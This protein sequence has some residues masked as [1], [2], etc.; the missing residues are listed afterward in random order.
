MSKKYLVNDQKGVALFTVVLIFLVLVTLLGGVMFAAV[1]NQ[2][3]SILAKDHTAVYYVAESGLNM[4][5]ANLESLFNSTTT[6][7]WSSS[8][9]FSEI[10]ATFGTNTYNLSENMGKA[11]WAVTQVSLSPATYAAYSDYVFIRLSS[12]GHIGDIS[13]DLYVDVGYKISLGPG[14]LFTF[15]GA[16]ITKEGITVDKSGATVIGPIASNMENNA[17]IDLSNTSTCHGVT[18]INIPTEDFGDV[19]G[20]NIPPSALTQDIVFSDITMPDR[21]DLLAR[22]LT[23]NVT[24]SSGV[25]D[26]RR[27]N[28][29][30]GSRIF[31]L[32]QLNSGAL[33]I[34][35]NGI[36]ERE[37]IFV[38]LDNNITSLPSSIT[39]EGQGRLIFIAQFSSTMTLN[40]VIRYR[41]TEGNL[42]IDPSKVNFVLFAQSGTTPGIRMQPSDVYAGSVLSNSTGTV[43][44]K[45]KF[46]G[47]FVTMSSDV[48]VQTPNS[49]SG[50]PENTIWVYAPYADFEMVANSMI[51]GS[52]MAESF[53][54]TNPHNKLIYKDLSG[55]YP[56]EPWTPLPYTIDQDDA[57]AEVEFKFFPIIEE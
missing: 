12:T 55:I 7:N 13:R 2:R 10:V 42:I 20:C 15:A 37:P 38:L 35:L 25:L 49:Q 22:R 30:Y 39:V 44:L 11:S 43:D 41:T 57:Q 54:S 6:E 52:I 47:Y 31:R 32:N 4:E 1:T 9:L 40:S 48:T 27:S 51:Y 24:I 56:F 5:I 53:S 29:P 23:P 46:G 26:L 28:I 33:T 3:N 34:R 19:S 21:A 18:E 14:T 45:G 17:T 50:T 36:D 8:R 16:V